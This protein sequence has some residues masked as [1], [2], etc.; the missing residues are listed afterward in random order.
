[1]GQTVRHLPRK[2]RFAGY[3][4]NGTMQLGSL[5]QIAAHTRRIVVGDFRQ[6]DIAL[7]NEGAPITGAAM[8]RLFAAVEESR[9]IVNIGGMSNFFYFPGRKARRAPAAAD[10]GPGNSLCDILASRLFGVPFDRGGKLARSGRTSQ[11]LLTLLL[12]QPYFKRGARSTGREEF[13][14][15]LADRLIAAGRKL[16]LEKADILATAAELTVCAISRSLRP[17]I[18]RDRTVRSLYLTGGGVHNRFFVERLRGLSDSL[19]V[20]SIA[21]LG[22]DS[23]LVEASAYA[24]MGEAAL[25][26]EAL[27]TRFGSGM[28]KPHR[29]VLGRIVQPPH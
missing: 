8:H 5:E 21:A 7:G 14:Q 2:T 15:R 22:Y 4:V 25:R 17:F 13:G 16:R 28:R 1:H 20:E 26:G 23:D 19:A 9:L 11:R 3:L 18:R 29:P 24:V 27:P 6:A 12:G 10:C